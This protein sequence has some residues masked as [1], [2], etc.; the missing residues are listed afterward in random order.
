MMKGEPERLKEMLSHAKKEP[1]DE[2]RARRHEISIEKCR[3]SLVEL[4]KGKRPLM[5]KWVKYKDRLFV[6][7]FK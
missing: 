2:S 4:P 7:G 6:K 1:M 5:C 3:Y